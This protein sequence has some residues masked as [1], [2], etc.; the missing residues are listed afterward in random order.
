ML[1]DTQTG[2]DGKGADVIL[3]SAGLGRDE[4]AQALIGATRRLLLLLAQVMQGG[5]HP[6]PRLVGI[7][8]DIV[9]IDAIGGEKADHRPGL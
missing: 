5:E 8:L 9:V 2:G 3:E 4:I 7:D 6:G 1:I